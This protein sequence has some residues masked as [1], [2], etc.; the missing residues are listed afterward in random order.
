MKDFK[1]RIIL[2]MLDTKLEKSQL[3]S[4]PLVCVGGSGSGVAAAMATRRAHV[5]KTARTGGEGKRRKS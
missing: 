2:L 3:L 5:R 1:G 4:A